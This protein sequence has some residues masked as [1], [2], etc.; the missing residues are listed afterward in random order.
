M[1]LPQPRW[2]A[3]LPAADRPYARRRFLLRIAALYASEAGH[4]TML[5]RQI[6]LATNSLGPFMVRRPVKRV[7]PG[8]ARKIEKATAK[9]VLADDLTS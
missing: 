5:A 3:R 8:M 7:P 4:A 6:G 9:V 1:T 2:L